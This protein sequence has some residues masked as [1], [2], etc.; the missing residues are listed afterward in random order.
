MSFQVDGKATL[1]QQELQLQTLETF[2]VEIVDYSAGADS[3]NEVTVKNISGAVT[4]PIRLGAIQMPAD[5]A[6]LAAGASSIV[7]DRTVFVQSKR[8]RVLGFRS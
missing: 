8:Q 6:K 5:L 4:S 1:A 2:F 3:K 7:F